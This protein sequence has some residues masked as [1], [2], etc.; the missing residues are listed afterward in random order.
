VKEREKI[1]WL[2]IKRFYKENKNFRE[3]INLIGYIIG[4]FIALS[5]VTFL[6]WLVII[7]PSTI[8]GLL[9]S[10]ILFFAIF[11]GIMISTLDKS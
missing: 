7:L 3:V 10:L 2:M 6:F 5:I 8:W 9:F 1:M 4:T 11:T